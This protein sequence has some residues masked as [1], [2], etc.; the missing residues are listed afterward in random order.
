[1]DRSRTFVVR[2]GANLDEESV[3]VFLARR[4]PSW[5]ERHRPFTPEH[6]ARLGFIGRDWERKGLP[7]LVGAAEILHHRGR[8]IRV[9]VIG[10]CPEHLQRHPQ[11][12]A[13]GLLSKSTEMPRFLEAVDRFALGCLP[14]YYEP[15]GISTLEALRLGVPVLGADVGGIPDCVP[16][17]AGFL[18][19]VDA[20]AEDIADAVEH[21]V[22]DPD[23]YAGLVRGAVAESENV[24]W[25]KTVE[26]L[27]RVWAGLEP[28]AFPEGVNGG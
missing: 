5:R 10:H 12:E 26:K 22:L 18:V 20:T 6:P 11:V 24:T 15:L 3:R 4:G 23:R 1:M 25:E 28:P 8:P 17:G 16:P 27:A 7:R 13:L 2:P 19:P 21:H 14:S 9:T